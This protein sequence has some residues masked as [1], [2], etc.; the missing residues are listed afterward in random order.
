MCYKKHNL[1]IEYIGTFI[2][3]VES[4]AASLGC[5]DDSYE[6]IMFKQ[7]IKELP[8][9]KD[10]V[11][12]KVTVFEEKPLPFRPVKSFYD[13]CQEIFSESNYIGQYRA[14]SGCR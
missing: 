8:K 9:S 14:S 7:E 12:C 1:K 10:K 4:I 3:D 6:L 13:T 2:G 11:N 5:E